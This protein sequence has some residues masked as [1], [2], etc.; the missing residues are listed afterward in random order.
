MEGVKGKG[1]K[2]DQL[3]PFLPALAVQSIIVGRPKVLGPVEAVRNH[4]ERTAR[5]LG[6]VRKVVVEGRCPRRLLVLLGGLAG[7]SRRRFLRAGRSHALTSRFEVV[8]RPG[9]RVHRCVFEVWS[10]KG[11]CVFH[12]W[13]R[14]IDGAILD[15]YPT[16]FVG[17]ILVIIH[18]KPQ[19]RSCSR[20]ASCRG[21][22]LS[23]ARLRAVGDI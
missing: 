4:L 5:L 15:F 16:H 23:S 21:R 12:H 19:F 20:S 6:H 17:G 2:H 8:L 1:R 14:A 18:R 22:T 9:R 3:T 7:G 11:G 13:V 10:R